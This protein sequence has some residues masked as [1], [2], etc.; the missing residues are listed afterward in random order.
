MARFPQTERIGW[1]T[2]ALSLCLL[3]SISWSVHQAADP[4][5]GTSWEDLNLNGNVREVRV[6]EA[7]I[8]SNGTSSREGSRSP[9]EWIV[10]DSEGHVVEWVE[11]GRTGDAEST[12]HFAYEDG[13]LRRQ[14]EYGRWSW[15]S[16]TI[17]YTHEQAG[18]RTTAEVLASDGSLRKTAVYERD[19]DGKLLSVTE[20]DGDGAEITCVVYTYTGT[21]ERA[22]RYDPD[23]ELIS[24]SLETFDAGGL[25][26][27]I[28]LHTAASDDA[29]FAIT[30]E[31]DENGNVSIET[32]SGR[33]AMPIV[34]MTTTPSET[35]TRYEYTYDDAG[36]WTKRVTSIWVA[37]DEP[38]W[39]P[40]RAT[41][42]TLLYE[43]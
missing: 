28:E 23:G 10:F 20:S 36:N 18:M 9:V 38:Y 15:P 26:T 4:L 30:Y 31:Y 14:E 25:L 43:E 41:Y 34:V 35:K 33:L 6:E 19:A 11:I 12:R 1:P 32:T 29:P 37:N 3:A 27:R 39:R 21:T 5:H 16:E 24:W 17:V 40:T 42:R 2:R 22:D 8:A 7:P 13:R